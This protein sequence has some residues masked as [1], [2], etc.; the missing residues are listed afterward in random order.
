MRTFSLPIQ[1][2]GNQE[3]GVGLID[4]LCGKTTLY[5]RKATAKTIA[6]HVSFVC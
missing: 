1:Y 2:V 4:F 6:K 5:S 3:M